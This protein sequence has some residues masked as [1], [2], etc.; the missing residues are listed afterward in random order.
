M[1]IIVA[2]AF[3][4]ASAVVAFVSGL[5]VHCVA[6]ALGAGTVTLTKGVWQGGRWRAEGVGTQRSCLFTEGD[7]CLAIVTAR[8]RG[9]AGGVQ[10]FDEGAQGGRCIAEGGRHSATPMTGE[11]ADGRPPSRGCRRKY[12]TR[13]EGN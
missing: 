10:P 4:V 11:L 12:L 2:I 9:G 1:V 3:F 7:R 6:Q 13:C 5:C 8:W